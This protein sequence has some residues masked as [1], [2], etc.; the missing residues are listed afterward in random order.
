MPAKFDRCVKSGGKVRTVKPNKSTYLHVC[1]PKGG[2][3]TVAG[4]PKKKK[5]K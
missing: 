5:G 3:K 2:K 4:Y 1:K